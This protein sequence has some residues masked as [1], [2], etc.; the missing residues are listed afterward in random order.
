MI[1]SDITK[2]IKGQSEEALQQKCYYWFHN[3][4]PDLRGLL[5]HIPNGGSRSSSEGKKFKLVGVIPGVADLCFLY[6]SQAYFIELK[7]DAFSKQSK[8]QKDWEDKV[9]SQGFFYEVIYSLIDFQTLIQT[10][11]K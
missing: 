3:N 6:N 7:K 8:K 5:F 10:I 2:D 11:V 4:Y 9:S 1:T